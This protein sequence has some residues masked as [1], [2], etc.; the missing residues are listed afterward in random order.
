MVG[1]RIKQ[2]REELGLSQEK[3]AEKLN[4]SSSSIA[5]YETE[6]RQPNNETLIKLAKIFDCSVD[7]LLGNTDIRNIEKVKFA[8]SGGIDTEGLSKD[9]IE[10]LRK[11]VEYIRWRKKNGN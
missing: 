9:E 11:Q 1:L 8:N 10:E 6:R 7:Y 3:L 5:M 2:L 4:A